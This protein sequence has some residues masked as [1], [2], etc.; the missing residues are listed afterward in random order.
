[1]EALGKLE[2]IVELYFSQR[3]SL[4]KSKDANG[5]EIE[6]WFKFESRAHF[7]DAYLAYYRNL[8]DLKA[9]ILNG[10]SA[11]FKIIYDGQEYELK[12]THQEE[13]KDDKGNIRGVNNSVLSEMALKLVSKAKQF[14]SAVSFDDVYNI[15]KSSRVAGFGE[16][17]IYDAAVRISAYLGYK[18]DKVFLHAG[19]R[20]GAESLE[21]KGLLPDDSS[22]EETL[23]ISDFPTPIQKL[24][25]L[26]IENFLCS[27]KINIT[28]L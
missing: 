28:K 9:A 25:A 19:A 13:F 20:K 18:P 24:D 5:E 27:F 4:F 23:L 12:H 3:Y 10:C 2:S 15:V 17:S 22:V 21:E 11:K 6:K 7:L 16:L 8:P 14:D 1:M 26:Q